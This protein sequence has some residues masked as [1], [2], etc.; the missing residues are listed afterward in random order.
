MRTHATRLV[1]SRPRAQQA[2]PLKKFARLLPCHASDTLTN[3]ILNTVRREPPRQQRSPCVESVD[4][5][6]SHE[7]GGHLFLLVEPPGE[8]AGLPPLP[9]LRRLAVVVERY[10]GEPAPW[11]LRSPPLSQRIRNQ[12][13]IWILFRAS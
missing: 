4:E 9:P 5:V 10:A 2:D 11:L 12:S 8:A 7:L 3:I 13:G 1:T 6:G